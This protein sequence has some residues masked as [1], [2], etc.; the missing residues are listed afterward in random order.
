MIDFPDDAALDALRARA[1]A[2]PVL[3]PSA[4]AAAALEAL[5]AQPLVWRDF[6]LADRGRYRLCDSFQNPELF[7]DLQTLAEAIADA[8]TRAIAGWRWTRH[9]QG[10]YA[11][12]KDDALA[13]ARRGPGLEVVLDFSAAA[14]DEGEIVWQ[15][16][17][18]SFALPNSPGALAIVDRRRPWLRYERYLGHRFGARAIHRLRLFLAF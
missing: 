2:G 17:A 18:A 14:S 4:L 16:D 5:R 10:D 6:E 3:V 9:E 13:A 1:Q 11:L 15:G 8:P 7:A 12:I